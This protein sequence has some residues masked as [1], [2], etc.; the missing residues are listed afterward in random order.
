MFGLICGHPFVLY[1]V[2]IYFGFFSFSN[3]NK[4]ADYPSVDFIHQS[5]SDSLAILHTY[6]RPHLLSSDEPLEY[7]QKLKQTVRPLASIA[8]YNSNLKQKKSPALV[9]SNR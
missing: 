6:L 7:V 1:S 8:A 2:K 9:E 4:L 5:L 3:Y